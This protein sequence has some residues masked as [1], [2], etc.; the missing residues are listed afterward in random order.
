MTMAEES[1]AWPMVSRPTYL[2]GLGF[3]LKWNMGWMHDMLDYMATDPIYR[4][5]HHNKITF[6]LMY[7]F[8]EN[9]LLPLSHDEVLHGK[10]SMIGRMA[11]DEWQKF[12][13]LRAFY[14]YMFTHPGKKLLFMGNEIGQWREWN[15]DSS[16]DWDLLDRP[17]HRGLQHWVRDLNTLLRETP[18]LHQVDFDPGGFEW[19]DCSDAQN[20]VIAFLRHG[21][22]R[23]EP[24]LVVCNFTPVLRPGYRIGVPSGGFW[25]ERLNSDAALYGGGDQG[26]MGGVT[27]D[28]TPAHG[29][30][31]SLVLTLPPLST[32]VFTPATA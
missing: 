22:G 8:S 15:A 11:G 7:A 2:G 13:N 26:N 32:C 9:F 17:F 21:T 10:G 18:A 29:R 6:S 14:G 5:H 4:S 19:I 25:R 23:R 24:V 3:G 1:T 20:S 12:A 28:P 30:D 27:A 16:L 31:Q